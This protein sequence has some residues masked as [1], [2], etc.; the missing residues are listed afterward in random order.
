MRVQLL[1]SD[2]SD[3][4]P[5][6]IACYGFLRHDTHKVMLRFVGGRPLGELTI[7]FLGWLCG[8]VAQE[9]KQVLVV[10]WDDAS[11]HT[12][13]E[14]A[15]WVEEQNHR[16][17]RGEGVKVMICELPVASP[18]LNNIEPCWT[19]AKKAVMEVDRKLTAAEIT[20][21]VCEHFKCERLPYLKADLVRDGE[22]HNSR[23]NLD[24]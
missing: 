9:G 10:I 6:A 12:S 19:Y 4:D 13:E 20:N 23:V 22:L 21:R 1:K 17:G 15:H 2:A 18:W 11:W 8:C 16:A 5:D 3:P 7:Q 14:V 24:L